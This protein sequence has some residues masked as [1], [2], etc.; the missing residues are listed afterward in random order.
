M[1]LVPSPK[2]FKLKDEFSNRGSSA[3]RLCSPNYEVLGINGRLEE[4]CHLYLPS[5][6]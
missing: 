1:P 2:V 3:E 5:R 6:I 4:R